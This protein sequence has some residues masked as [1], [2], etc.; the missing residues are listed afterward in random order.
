M[1]ETNKIIVTVSRT[2]NTGNYES[3][4]FGITREYYEDE[5]PVQSMFDELMDEIELAATRHSVW[6]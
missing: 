4:K 5:K 1:G 6:R 2:Y 3:V